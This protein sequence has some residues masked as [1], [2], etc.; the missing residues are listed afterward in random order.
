MRGAY[1]TIAIV[2]TQEFLRPAAV[3]A[4]YRPKGVS[5]RAMASYWVI[6]KDFDDIGALP[7]ARF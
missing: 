6:F 2:Q 1:Y 5:K 3:M 4:I 7:L